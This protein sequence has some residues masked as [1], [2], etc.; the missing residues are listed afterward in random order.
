MKII[1]IHKIAGIVALITLVTFFLS[2]IIVESTGN[3][4]WIKLLKL[5]IMIFALG[6][7]VPSTIIVGIT[8]K[9]MGKGYDPKL[10]KKKL[11]LFKA[12]QR[13]GPFVLAPTGIALYVLARGDNFNTIAFGNILIL[14]NHIIGNP[15]EYF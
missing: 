4:E 3:H 8:G 1:Q 10:L 9:K 7:M 2:T 13:I 12:I 11:K 14:F 5:L 6:L 15:G